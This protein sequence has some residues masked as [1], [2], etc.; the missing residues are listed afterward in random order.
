VETQS[1]TINITIGRSAFAFDTER[2]AAIHELDE[3]MD[4]VSARIAFFGE[5]LAS[6]SEE[7]VNVDAAYRNWR[8][9]E[10]LKALQA[11]PKIAEWKVRSEIEASD[12]FKKFKEAIARAEYNQTSL[13]TLIRALEEKSPNLRSKGAR[14]R[15]ELEATDMSTSAQEHAERN[16]RELRK[17]AQEK[18]QTKKGE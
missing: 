6:A 16:T 4:T 17:L 10:S 11:D 7:A 13:K 15:A 18:T 12:K 1:R 14:Q 9:S 2:E 5:L 3:D 8:A